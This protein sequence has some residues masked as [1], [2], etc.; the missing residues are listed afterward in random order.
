LKTK[1]VNIFC[2]QRKI[3][4]DKIYRCAIL[5]LVEKYAPT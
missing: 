1:G 4:L 3:S 2:G 5:S